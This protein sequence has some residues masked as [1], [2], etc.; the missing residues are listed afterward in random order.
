MDAREAP[1]ETM[2]IEGGVVAGKVSV[3]EGAVPSVGAAGTSKTEKVL[4]LT[5]TSIC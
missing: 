1:L 4:P 2:E 3:N 5:S